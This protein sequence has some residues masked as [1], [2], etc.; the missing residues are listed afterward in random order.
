MS[1]DNQDR[2]AVEQGNAAFSSRRTFHVKD[3]EKL[4]ELIPPLELAR[5]FKP[6]AA[7]VDGAKKAE[8]PILEAVEVRHEPTFRVERARTKAATERQKQIIEETK[9]Q[10][11]RAADEIA[12]RL[13][14]AK[15]ASK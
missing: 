2:H 12:R 3:P 14:G 11:L 4:A 15:G 6:S 9:E 13:L 5:A 7:F 10:A 8:I 1:E